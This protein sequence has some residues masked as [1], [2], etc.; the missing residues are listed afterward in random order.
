[1][2]GQG[3]AKCTA[4]TGGRNHALPLLEKA[5]LEAVTG[6]EAVG[7]VAGHELLHGLEY[8]TELGTNQRVGGSS[9]VRR[10]THTNGNELEWSYQTHSEV[11]ESG[12]GQPTPGNV[13]GK[14]IQHLRVLGL[15]G[16]KRKK[17]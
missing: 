3:R 1:M 14:L 16:K 7:L 6:A 12:I 4:L 2:P 10:G 15:K 5:G 13:F 17:Y 11:V 9:R 8:H